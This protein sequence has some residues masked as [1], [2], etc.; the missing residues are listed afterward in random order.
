MTKPSDDESPIGFK[1][2]DPAGRLITVVGEDPIE[3]PGYYLV[4]R[5]DGARWGVR[6]ELLEDKFT[7]TNTPDGFKCGLTFTIRFELVYTLEQLARHHQTSPETILADLHT[8]VETEIRE[9]IAYLVEP[10]GLARKYY[11]AEILGTQDLEVTN[12]S[13]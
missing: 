5:E 9:D 11:A 4:E 8:Y 3:G 13:P 1:Y 12:A 6:A 7:T 2:Y 10:S